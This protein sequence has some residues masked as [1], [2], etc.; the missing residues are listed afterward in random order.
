M[1]WKKGLEQKC[2]LWLTRAKGKKK[3]KEEDKEG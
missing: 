2:K 1:N 3:E